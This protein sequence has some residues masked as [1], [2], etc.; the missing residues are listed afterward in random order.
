MG[1]WPIQGS[2]WSYPQY[3]EYWDTQ[4]ISLIEAI[5]NALAGANSWQCEYCDK[6]NQNVDRCTECGAPQ[7]GQNPVQ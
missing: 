6:P 7:N 4:R 3:N 5:D 1:I 2:H